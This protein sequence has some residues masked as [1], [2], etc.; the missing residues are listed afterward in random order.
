MIGQSAWSTLF[1]QRL[2]LP[3]STVVLITLIAYKLVLIGVG[4]WASKRNQDESD[5]FLGG[6]GLGPFVAGMSYAASTSSAWVIL[7][8]SGFVYTIGVGAL[9]MVPGIWAGYAVVWLYF[10]RRLREESLSSRQITLTDF[11]LQDAQPSAK[12]I[13]ASSSGKVN[14]S[15][16]RTLAAGVAALMT[17]VCFVFYIAAQFD[18]A[19][20]A[21]AEHFLI[22]VPQ[23]VVLGAAV[24][25][26]Y[27]LLGGFWAVS[28]TDSIQAIIMLLVALGVP[29]AALQASGGPTAMWHSLTNSMPASYLSLSGGHSGLV[30]PGF[31][32]GLVGMSLGALG[33]PHL[34]NRLMA[35]K[36]EAE[37]KRGFAIAMSWGV[38]VFLGMAV[39]GLSGRVLLPDIADPETLFYQAASAYLPAVLAGVVIAATLSAV[40][41]TVDSIMLAAAGAVAH[42]LGVNRRSK[43]KLLTSR[44]VMLCIAILAVAL[45]LVLP[46]SI[47][48]RVLFAWS[49]LGAAFGPI[50]LWRVSGRT[51]SARACLYSMLGGFMTTVL[52]YSYGA[53]P[54]T[55]SWLS[56]AAYLP[57]DPFERVFPWLPSLLLLGLCSRAESQTEKA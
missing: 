16:I 42:D 14:A 47:F 29:Y 53:A 21:L 10:G 46:D 24:V 54:A 12:Q 25:L 48:N 27:S 40:M 3:T 30:L 26:I 44:I 56:Q 57:G 55:T 9:W 49:A 11:L 35:I 8:F 1:L 15:S 5:F 52:F 23:A 22:S 38:A 43:H 32:I 7:G 28:V 41:S 39:L 2:D 37:R 20:K 34:L 4:V 18:A 50:V 13:A 33:Q 6:R 51:V 17:V 19:G 45:T 31:V 36:G